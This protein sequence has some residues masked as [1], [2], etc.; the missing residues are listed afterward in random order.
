MASI[1]G[2]DVLRDVEE[3]RYVLFI[4]PSRCKSIHLQCKATSVASF[5]PDLRLFLH[6]RKQG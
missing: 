3:K 6:S 2:V 4:L 1:E 5:S